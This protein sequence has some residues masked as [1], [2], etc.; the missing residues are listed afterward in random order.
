MSGA[1]PSVFGPQKLPLNRRPKVD[2][3]G[4]GSMVNKAWNSLKRQLSVI[5]IPSILAILLFAL[6][7][8]QVSLNYLTKS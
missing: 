2:L 1:A 8:F 4:A 7:I 6:I 5:A 3:D